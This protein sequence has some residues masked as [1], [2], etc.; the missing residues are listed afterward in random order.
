LLLGIYPKDGALYHK[1]TCSTVFIA[2]LFIIAKK[3]EN[4]QKQLSLNSRMDTG[5]AVH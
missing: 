1:D 4:K 2:A 3:L 5:N